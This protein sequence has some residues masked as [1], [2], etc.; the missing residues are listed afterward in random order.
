MLETKLI[1]NCFESTSK[2]MDAC[3]EIT[4]LCREINGDRRTVAIYNPYDI[5]DYIENGIMPVGT[6]RDAVTGR[7][8]HV[9]NED[10]I[11]CYHII[12]NINSENN[13]H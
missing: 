13:L 5:L 4:K 12:T 1:D 11:R 10:D 3:D 9:F 7:Q 2:I 8:G 6:I